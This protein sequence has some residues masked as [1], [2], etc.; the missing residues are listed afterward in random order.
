MS[1]KKKK[2]N[3]TS[4]TRGKVQK[5][6]TIII[7]KIICK[8]SYQQLSKT[9]ENFQQLS[10]RTQFDN[11][12]KL[13]INIENYPKKKTEKSTKLNPKI[14]KTKTNSQLNKRH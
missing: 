9:I 12:T 5:I 7:N 4:Q 11:Y 8:Y 14:Q 10:T 6:S 1:L 13:Y 3:S 2:K